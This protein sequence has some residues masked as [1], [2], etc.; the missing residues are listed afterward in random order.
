MSNLGLYQTM[1]SLAKKAGGPLKLAAYVAVG[2]YAIIRAGETGVKVAAKQI[3]KRSNNNKKSKTI[4]EYTIN[5]KGVSNEGLEFNVGDKFRV[6][7]TAEDAIL[8]EKIG[9]PNNPYFVLYELLQS[10]S[11]YKK[12]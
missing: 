8:I 9:A 5:T 7:E 12:T 6:L 10:I 3:K 4:F 2:G 11:D 1:T